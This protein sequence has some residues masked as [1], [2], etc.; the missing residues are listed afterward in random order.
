MNAVGRDSEL[1]VLQSRQTSH[2]LLRALS[3]QHCF[4]SMLVTLSIPGGPFH[5][6]WHLRTEQREQGTIPR[7]CPPF[8]M[9]V[10]VLCSEEPRLDLQRYQYAEIT[11]FA[12]RDINMH[13][14]NL[15]Y[16][17]NHHA[18]IAWWNSYLGISHFFCIYCHMITSFVVYSLDISWFL[19]C[20]CRGA[21]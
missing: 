9:Y 1:S 16:R 19:P 17:G 13:A 15:A 11:D 14:K 2:A 12:C 5:P 20:A 18:L 8:T 21:R 7:P 3:C 4:Q 6:C 10:F